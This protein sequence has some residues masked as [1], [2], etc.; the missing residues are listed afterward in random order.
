MEGG[1]VHDAVYQEGVCCL[2]W[3]VVCFILQRIVFAPHRL[4]LFQDPS[5]F[6]A[7]R[8]LMTPDDECTPS[9]VVLFEYLPIYVL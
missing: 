7:V 2:Q 4:Q 3:V 5:F 6:I 8:Y 1:C 9:H